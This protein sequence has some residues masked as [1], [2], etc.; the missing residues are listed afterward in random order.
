MKNLIL[1][2]V[3]AFSILLANS[4]SAASYYGDTYYGT[5]TYGYNSGYNTNYVVNGYS[6]EQ[7]VLDQYNFQQRELE[8]KAQIAQQKYYNE[9]QLLLQ[10][11]SLSLQKQNLANVRS[12]T[13]TTSSYV[14]AQPKVQYIA[15][16]TTTQIQ[17]VP[18]QQVQYVAQPT[19]VSYVPAN[20]Q[21]A[22][23]IGST[24]KVV[25]A[26]AGVNSNTGQYVN[27]DG[28]LQAASVYGYNGYNN[29]QVIVDPTYDPNGVTALSMNGSGGFLPTSVFQWFMFILLVLAIVIV[30]R[31]IIKK[32]AANNVHGAPVH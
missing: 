30:A 15:A 20:T 16:P 7:M 22:S 6:R 18:Q 32:N 4:V 25:Y 27:Y 26:N 5:D 12:N 28:N 8:A 13:S 31:I 9:Q 29:G 14:Y 23:V 19:T 1:L 11:Q 24:R 17:Y 3:F 2:S 10:Q 21:G